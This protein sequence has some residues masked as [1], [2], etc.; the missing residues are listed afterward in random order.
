MNCTEIE[1]RF[2]GQD[3]AKAGIGGQGI[4]HPRVLQAR[5]EEEGLKMQLTPEQTTE[6][7]FT[8]SS[9]WYQKWHRDHIH[10][11][12]FE[13]GECPDPGELPAESAGFRR[14]LER[15][16]DITVA[17]AGIEAHHHVV[18]AGCGVGGT[19]IYLAQTRGCRVTGVNL[20]RMQLEV[21]G[22]KAANRGVAD[23]VRFEYANCSE[24]LPFD[25]N[26]ID[27]VTNIE[28]ACHYGDRSQ[29]LREVKR[30]LKPGG[31]IVATDWMTCDGLSA[32]QY[33]TYIRPMLEPW[34]LAGMESR[35]TYTDLLRDV[36]LQL[37]EFEGF[38][39]RDSGNL[40]LFNRHR[41][42]VKGLYIFGMMPII[43]VH[44][45]ESVCRAWEIGYFCV[46]RYCAEKPPE[47]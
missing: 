3:D 31:R 36:G 16:L 6:Q 39:R 8:D 14:A 28:S 15:M 41:L 26:S 2:R 33:E 22:K 27:V 46:E 32:D 9:G 38:D 23:R 4:R 11:G 10:L 44:R 25:D 1:Y 20:H 5:R 13:P 19:A 43:I 29:F 40:H 45:M 47:A 42:I 34:A 12:V 24:H 17:P 35:S 30:I 37:I 18:D 21:A 7:H